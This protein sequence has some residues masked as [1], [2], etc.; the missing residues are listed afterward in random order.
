MAGSI[1]K[2]LA[3]QFR[4]YAGILHLRHGQDELQPNKRTNPGYATKFE[5]PRLF[6]GRM[7]EAARWSDLQG[8]ERP[9]KPW[10]NALPRLI[11]ISDMADA[12]SAT[13]GF[14]Y[15][16][17]EV[18]DNVASPNG[19]RHVWLWLSKRP[20]RMAEFSTWLLKHSIRWPDNL[21]AMTSVTSEKTIGRVEQLQ[22]VQ[23][24]LRGLSIE[25]LWSSVQLPLDGIDWA[26]VGGES[27]SGAKPFDLGWAR[28][29]LR[30]C[31][32]HATAPFVKQLGANPMDRGDRI[33][34][35]DS[36]GGDWSEWTDDLK[37]REFPEEFAC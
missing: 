15:L 5:T 34:L 27:G 17:A 12:L 7:Q 9:D 13:V 1:E 37:V 16:K 18:I 33:K 6:P 10:M 29:I 22:K 20:N 36:H 23:C 30:Q 8:S 24:K 19:Q 32:D 11:F 31:R 28:E 14:E 25:P 4:C 21:V 35:N 3:A 26:I 2:V